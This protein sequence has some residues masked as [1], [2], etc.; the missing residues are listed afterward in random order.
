MTTGCG[1][2]CAF[3]QPDLNPR[4]SVPKA[5]ILKAVAGNVAAGNRQ[6]SLATE[7]M[8]VWRTDEAGLPFFVPNRMEL[9]DLYR[10]I[11]DVPGVKEVTLSHATIAPALVD[12]DLIAELSAL[13]ID[14]SP[15]RLRSVSSH[16]ECRALAPLIGVETGS[17]RVARQIM[18]KGAAIRHQGL[19]PHRPERARGAEPAQ[20]VPGVHAHRPIARRD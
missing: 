18:V 15:I 9:L 3:C 17:V 12:P 4:V 8:F 6:V 10:S 16:P 11:V 1:R 5:E 7:D 19:A 13:L 14:R 2:R 20:L